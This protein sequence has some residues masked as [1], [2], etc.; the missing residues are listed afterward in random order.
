MNRNKLIIVMAAALLSCAPVRAP[1]ADSGVSDGASP[2]DSRPAEER[3]ASLQTDALCSGRAG[4]TFAYQVLSEVTRVEPGSEVL[5]DN[6]AAFFFLRGDCHY[7]VL[8]SIRAEVREG[9][10]TA[11]EVNRQ[12]NLP[13]LC[14]S[15]GSFRGSANDGSTVRLATPTVAIDCTFGCSGGAVSP[16]LRQASL[17]A[18]SAARAFW[19]RAQPVT[20]GYRLMAVSGVKPQPT[21]Q[22]FDWP[23]QRPI[24]TVSVSVEQAI[25]LD[26]G[27]SHAVTD[28]TEV[29][30]LTDLRR[31]YLMF[32][33]FQ[34]GPYIRVVS[35]GVEHALWMRRSIPLENNRGIV[36]VETLL[37]V[38]SR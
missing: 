15:S 10:T 17:D 23:L 16:V 37:S 14:G 7:W 9:V 29:S 1:D 38:P 4:L 2:S 34:R 22:V 36:P 30:L 28:P 24:T 5:Y 27:S 20:A 26:V 19:E 33:E 12:F 21:T 6:G 3:C 25:D 18:F 13:R 32:S 35:M 31:R 8:E 11:A